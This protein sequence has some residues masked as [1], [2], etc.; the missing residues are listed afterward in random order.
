MKNIICIFSKPPLAGMTKSRL[1]KTIGST[2]AAELS[3]A[4]LRDIITQCMTVINAK[5]YIAYPPQSTPNE[6]ATVHQSGIN[7]IVQQGNNL[8][9]RMSNIFQTFLK[10]KHA[11]KVII[12]GSDCIT[13]ST[14]IIA[15]SL[16]KLTEFPVVIGPAR[17]GGY[18]LVGQS[19]FTPGMFMNIDWGSGK[20]MNQTAVLLDSAK[21]KY[22]TMPPSFDIDHHEDLAELKIFL[23]ENSRP[24]TEKFLTGLVVT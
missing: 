11:A 16:T 12:I 14:A 7:Y 4:M 19:I 3:A 13:T 15:E 8:G 22:Y 17:D 5:V 21:V 24:F 10:P 6:F 2:A 18:V 23:K 9:E 1:A 20:V